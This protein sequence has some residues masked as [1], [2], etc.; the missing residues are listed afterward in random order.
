MTITAFARW[1]LIDDAVLSHLGFARVCLTWCSWFERLR[2]KPPARSDLHAHG[3]SRTFGAA[4]WKRASRQLN[5]LCNVFLFPI[6]LPRVFRSRLSCCFLG[7]CRGRWERPHPGPRLPSRPAEPPHR[8]EEAG[9]KVGK[10]GIKKKEEGEAGFE[11]GER[12]R[13]PVDSIALF[14]PFKQRLSPLFLSVV[15]GSEGELSPARPVFAVSQLS[16]VK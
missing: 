6:R 3:D 10:N 1:R 9:G 2:S 8:R 7:R 16:V 14:F 13:P 5:G 4:S 11:C 15:R 12:H